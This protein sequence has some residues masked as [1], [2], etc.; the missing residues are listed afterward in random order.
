MLV[1]CIFGMLYIWRG[2]G[3]QTPLLGG[4]GPEVPLPTS[5]ETAIPTDD[6][7]QSMD[8]LF[9]NTIMPSLAH[10]METASEG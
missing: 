8:Y 1:A 6:S 5:L 10:T 3:S 4:D 2:C 7:Q 9:D